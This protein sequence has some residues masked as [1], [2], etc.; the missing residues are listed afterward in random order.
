VLKREGGEQ[1]QVDDDRL[2]ERCRPAAVFGLGH[3]E[4]TEPGHRVEKRGEKNGVGDSAVEQHENALHDFISRKFVVP[5]QA[6]TQV[7]VFK[8]LSFE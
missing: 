4:T 3:D 6:G 8:L 1:Q 5:A 7:R 2:P